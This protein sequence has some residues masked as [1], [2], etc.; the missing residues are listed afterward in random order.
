MSTQNTLTPAEKRKATIAARAAKE[1]E[2]NIAFQNQSRKFHRHLKLYSGRFTKR[3]EATGGRQA[4][5]AA[6]EN[7]LWNVDQ[8]SSRKRTSSTAQVPEVPAKKAREMDAATGAAGSNNNAEA[9]APPKTKSNVRKHLAPTIID[10]DDEPAPDPALKL[11]RHIDFSKLPGNGKSVSKGAS[12]AYGKATVRKAVPATAKPPVK[13]VADS[14]SEDE[15]VAS[16]NTEE[17]SDDSDNTSGDDDDVVDVND[18]I[19]EVP[20]V[21]STHFKTTAKASETAEVPQN[22]DEHSRARQVTSTKSH[23][24]LKQEDPQALFDS[25]LEDY[26][27]IL[28]APKKK[29]TGKL[30]ALPVPQADPGSEDSMPD[31]PPAR[32]VTRR[33][34]EMRDDAAPVQYRSRRSSMASSHSSAM[35]DAPEVHPRM[36]S[37]VEFAEAMADALVTIP[38]PRSHCSSMGSTYSS[39]RDLS[40]PASEVESEGGSELDIEHNAEAQHPK[41]KTKKV[42]AARQRQA[43]SERPEIKPST[44]NKSKGQAPLDA[45]SRLESSW[46]ITAQL[47]LPAPNKDIGLTAQHPELQAVLRDTML[48][49]KIF[50]LF[51]EAY[52]LMAS[53]AGFGRPRM[54]EP[55][56][57][58]NILRGN[59]KRCAVNCVLA[60]FGFA[61]LTPDEVKARVE[62]LLKDHR[63]IFPTTAGRLHL[64]QPFRHGS[65]R[66]VI[67]EEVFSNT[68]FVTQN[69][70][71]FP[72]RLPKKPT[73]RELPDPMVA[74]GA[75]AVY[76]SL[77]EYR[78]TGRRQNIPFTEDAYEDIYRN[79]IATLEQ[80]RKNARK[81]MHRILHELFTEVTEGNKVMHTASGSSSTL[82]QLVDIP[83]SD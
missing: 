48:I 7:A 63:Y 16:D 11:G 40:V 67:K 69:I 61:D 3:T 50:M 56:D 24:I 14:A 62:E 71:R 74:L 21:V 66:F 28:P 53:R 72:A 18:F 30:K 4:K 57:R 76:A 58:M 9:L 2:E 45:S 79:H 13:I 59:F 65:I 77:V 17:D 34:I 19:A 81:G 32:R 47:V 6:K 75:T 39:R 78:M 26:D 22:V 25:D 23:R 8:S 15:T 1:I 35:S 55:I 68:S 20:R 31:A 5:K 82:I 60:F 44:L 37:D 46:D 42:S 52:P 12:T 70:D 80:T 27:V 54:I 51:T 33:D 49:I 38:I 41:K 64:D 10:S 83:D 36:D 43:D 73:E 29:S